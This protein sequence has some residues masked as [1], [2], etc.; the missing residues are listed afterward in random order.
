MLEDPKRELAKVASFLDLSASPE[1]LIRAVQLSSADRMRELEKKQAADWALTKNTHLD[2]AFVRKATSGNWQVELP[3]QTVACIER[4]WG[5]L[6]QTLGYE[7]VSTP[8]EV[9]V[10]R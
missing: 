8:E 10:T 4:A 9:S 7:L 2:M 3:P 5:S 6:M 1:S